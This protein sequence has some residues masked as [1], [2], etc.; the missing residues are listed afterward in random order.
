MNAD[1]ALMRADRDR[2]EK[3][4]SELE[5]LTDNE[6]ILLRQKIYPRQNIAEYN[7]EEIETIFAQWTKHIREII[8]TAKGIRRINEALGE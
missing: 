6:M 5:I 8:E 2:L 1:I 4:A 7:L 3:R